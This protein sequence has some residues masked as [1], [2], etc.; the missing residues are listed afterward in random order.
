MFCCLGVS[1]DWVECILCQ[2]CGEWVL[3]WHLLDTVGIHPL[4]FHL[5]QGWELGRRYQ[6]WLGFRGFQIW[7]STI[8]LSVILLNDHCQKPEVDVGKKSAKWPTHQACSPH[9][10]LSQHTYHD[11]SATSELPSPNCLIAGVSLLGRNAPHLQRAAAFRRI[12]LA[13]TIALLGIHS[14]EK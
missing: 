3:P 12:Q 2:F 13:C 5:V 9:Q 10:L 14:T 1:S 11:W 4:R 6:I 7:V 8:I